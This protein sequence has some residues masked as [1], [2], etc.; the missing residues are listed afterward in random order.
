MLY[1]KCIIFFIFIFFLGGGGV[2]GGGRGVCVGG[3]EPEWILVWLPEFGARPHLHKRGT[4][5]PIIPE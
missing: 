5:G 1:K 2:R 4:G 3:G